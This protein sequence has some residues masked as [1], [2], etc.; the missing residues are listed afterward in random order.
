MGIGCRWP[1]AGRKRL[2]SPCQSGFGETDGFPWTQEPCRIPPSGV[3]DGQTTSEPSLAWCLSSGQARL[4]DRARE[5][6]HSLAQADVASAVDAGVLAGA[7]EAREVGKVD[8]PA[9]WERA[10][11]MTLAVA[12]AAAQVQA[13][14][15]PASSDAPHD[16][17]GLGQV[18]PVI[19]SSSGAGAS[20]VATLLA[21][22]L[23]TLSWRVLLVDTADPRRYGLACAARS[24]GPVREG[25][26]ETVNIRMS[27]RGHAVVA[28]LETTLPMLS[29][30]LVPPPQFWMPP[31]STPQATVVD[32]SYDAWRLAAQPLS[33]P[34]A[35]LRNGSPT[36]RPILL[37]RPSRPSLVQAEQV[38]ARL[39]TW[40][41]TGIAVA[42]DALVVVGAKKWP[43]GVAGAAG[44]RVSAL[45]D[46]AV[47]LPHDKEIATGG[48]GPDITPARLREA[49]MPLLRSWGLVPTSGATR[50]LRKGGQ[51]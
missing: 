41:A 3:Q 38:L 25:P 4:A 14:E 49:V 8:V 10:R 24:D 31:D 43:D 17:S 11:A 40:T 42:P 32:L 29:P 30:G 28:H 6:S 9:V 12:G 1:R 21:D 45:L 18:I 37:V 35:W 47:F 23:Q 33:G 19:P 13:Q 26:H 34:G 36:P 15:P 27:Q 20:V 48:I 2:G 44:R 7:T 51:R 50:L 39:E 5:A 22:A 46:S 16:Y